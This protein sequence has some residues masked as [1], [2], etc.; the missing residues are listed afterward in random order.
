MDLDCGI[1]TPTTP[2]KMKAESK[3]K[4]GKG[5]EPELELSAVQR[6]NQ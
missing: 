6:L 5:E 1:T 2:M 4:A 3:P